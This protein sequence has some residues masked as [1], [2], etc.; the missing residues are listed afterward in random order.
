MFSSEEVG[1]DIG[2]KFTTV[3]RIFLL[4]GLRQVRK[5]V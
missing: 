1:H 3:N 2:L 4:P 5:T